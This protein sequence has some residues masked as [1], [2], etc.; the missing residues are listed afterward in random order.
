MGTAKVAISID[1]KVLKKVDQ[2]VKKKI[3]KNRSQAFQIAVVQ[4]L[5]HLEHDRL[6]AECAKL[7][8]DA[9]RNMAEIGLNEDVES[10]PEY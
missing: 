2:F 8:K 6:A 3:F 4:E 1:S 5:E 10:W 9:E 7:D